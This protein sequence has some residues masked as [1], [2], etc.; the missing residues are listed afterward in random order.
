MGPPAPTKQFPHPTHPPTQPR[1]HLHLSHALRRLPV[2]GEMPAELV[3][4]PLR[5]LRRLLGL[6]RTLVERRLH[7]LRTLRLL[8]EGRLQLGHLGRLLVELC[9][10]IA[11]RP[12][13]RLLGAARLGQRA[14][15]GVGC[16]PGGL[17]RRLA[18]QVH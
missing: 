9:L 17:L 12:L 6:L 10:S 1:A 7:L 15:G 16:A 8:R 14:A 18:L 2:P 11:L 13:S 3:L 4:Q 5:T